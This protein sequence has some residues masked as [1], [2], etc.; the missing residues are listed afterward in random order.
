MQG[1]GP[2][3]FLTMGLPHVVC[4]ALC[5]PLEFWA[6]DSGTCNRCLSTRYIQWG[7]VNPEGISDLDLTAQWVRCIKH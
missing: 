5:D 4:T 3:D 1:V 6:D 2:K 7:A